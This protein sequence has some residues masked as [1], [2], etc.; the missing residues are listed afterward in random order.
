MAE[1][2]KHCPFCGGRAVITSVGKSKHF[3]TCTICSIMKP[4]RGDKWYTSRN[5]AERAWNERTNQ[6]EKADE[7][8]KQAVERITGLPTDLQS[9]ATAYEQGKFDAKMDAEQ[10]AH[11]KDGAERR[12]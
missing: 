7:A 8:I 6:S 5:G 11:S 2:L 9:Y 1:K 10:I 3:V 4:P 12:W